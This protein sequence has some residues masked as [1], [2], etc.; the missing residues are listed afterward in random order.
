MDRR[1]RHNMMVQGIQGVT[2]DITEK[3]NAQEALI[4]RQRRAIQQQQSILDFV[5]SQE[6]I[7]GNY[8]ETINKL[9][10][11]SS[12]WLNVQRVAIWLLDE[13]R[14]LLICKFVHDP[15]RE[16]LTIGGAIS[17]KKFP[18]YFDLLET[19]RTIEISD[20]PARRL[21]RVAHV[22][23]ITVGAVSNLLR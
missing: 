21:I 19:S 7:H 3:K 18:V 14:N 20:A 8:E 22:P 11:L 15:G 16:K 17:R 13:R 1:Y 4:A 2:R 10:E 5:T 12:Q 6:V 23:L 9:A